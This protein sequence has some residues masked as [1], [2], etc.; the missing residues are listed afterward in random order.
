MSTFVAIGALEKKI[1]ICDCW[2]VVTE[3]AE[4]RCVLPEHYMEICDRTC[5]GTLDGI[6]IMKA[7]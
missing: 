5:Y 6:L 2:L 3:V 7:L 1:N 4:Y